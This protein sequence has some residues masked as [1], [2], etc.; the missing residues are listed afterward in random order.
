MP[1][2]E[3]IRGDAN[4]RGGGEQGLL[5][6][7]AIDKFPLIAKSSPGFLVN[8]VLGALHDGRHAAREKGEAKEKIDEAARAFG[9][10]MGPDRAGRHRR[11]RR[12][13][14]RRQASSSTRPTA[15][16]LDQMVPAGKLGKKIGRR[17]LRLEGRQA[18]EGRAATLRQAELE[19]L[20]RELVEPLIA[21]GERA[22]DE[23]IVESADLVDAGVIFGTGFAP[24][25]GGPLHFKA[26]EQT[27]ERRRA[28]ARRGGVNR[29]VEP[30]NAS[31]TVDDDGRS[32]SFM[33]RPFGAW[34]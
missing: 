22:R 33:T 4:A 10:P 28:Q 14:P 34:R 27:A 8:R 19:R 23:R 26:T 3:V 17:L 9:M 12:V 32:R 6:V 16:K 2:V 20:G 11:P 21:R 1:L 24:F 31:G 15:R 30:C 13:R 7:T 29:C 5:F 18:R 25:R